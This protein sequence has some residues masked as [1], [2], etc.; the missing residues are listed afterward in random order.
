MR[1]HYEVGV[2]VRPGAR[3]LIRSLQGRLP[4]AVASNTD[5]D[6]VRLALEVAGLDDA[7]AAIVTAVEVGRGKPHPDVYI[8]ACEL[9]GVPPDDAVAFEDSPLGVRAA[10]A[11]GMT[12]VGIPERDGVDLTTNGADLVVGSLAE[13]VDVAPTRVG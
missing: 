11:A 8:T 4:L 9:L 7:F 3:E 10:K 5:G 1:D 13:L 12:C 6:L 2:P